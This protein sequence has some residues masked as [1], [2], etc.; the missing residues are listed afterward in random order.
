MVAIP[1]LSRT[2]DQEHNLDLHDYDRECKCIEQLRPRVSCM[3]LL[4]QCDYA[5]TVR[6]GLAGSND[7]ILG[8]APG[9]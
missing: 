5:A 7:T 6:V 3:L 9:L 4:H 1:Q 8:P 2:M